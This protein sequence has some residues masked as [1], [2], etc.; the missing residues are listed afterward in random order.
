MT[1]CDL[2]RRAVEACFAVL[3]EMPNVEQTIGAEKC[4]SAIEALPECEAAKDKQRIAF[5]ESLLRE[6]AIAGDLPE[7]TAMIASCNHIAN[8]VTT[9]LRELV[10][11]QKDLA[12]ANAKIAELKSLASQISTDWIPANEKLSKRIA[13]LEHHAEAMAKKLWSV[14]PAADELHAYEKSKEAQR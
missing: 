8:H 13:E 10:A 1:H 12:A 3:Y 5:L 7:E 14:A 9:L 6:I 2:K 11:H 4:V